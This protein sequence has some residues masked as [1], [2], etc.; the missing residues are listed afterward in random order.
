MFRECSGKVGAAIL[1]AYF[2][3][4]VF[5]QCSVNPAGAKFHRNFAMLPRLSELRGMTGWC[6]VSL[7]YGVRR[8]FQNFDDVP[9][10]PA[11]MA[12]AASRLSRGRD[13][14]RDE[15]VRD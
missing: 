5:R 11:R 9:G 13:D 12:G 4:A 10:H 7:D 8:P 15:P 1:P 6:L 3:N 14:E 2:C